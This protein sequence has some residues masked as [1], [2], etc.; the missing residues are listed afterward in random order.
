MVDPM[1]NGGTPVDDPLRQAVKSYKEAMR[2]QMQDLDARFFLKTLNAVNESS[3]LKVAANP[4][5]E[6]GDWIHGTKLMNVRGFEVDDSGRLVVRT[7]G[8]NT[9]MPVEKALDQLEKLQRKLH[10]G[11]EVVLELKG[12]KYVQI[13]DVYSHAFVKSVFAGLPFDLVLAYYEKK[14]EE[15]A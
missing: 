3:V 15:E 5:D 12:E 13:T 2:T 9:E 8:D 6:K 14:P 4:I 11:A 1:L 10:M 7:R